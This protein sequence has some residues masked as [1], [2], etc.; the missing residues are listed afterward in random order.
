[1]LLLRKV[2]RGAVL[3]SGDMYRFVSSDFKM[4][5]PRSIC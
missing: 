2:M 3:G 1:M 4:Y 5:L